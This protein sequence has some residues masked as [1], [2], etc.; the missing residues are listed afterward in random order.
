MSFLW[1]HICNTCHI[2]L[3]PLNFAD[4]A[5]FILNTP[6]PWR[7]GGAF[8]W[9]SRLK[10]KQ[11]SSQTYCSP[12]LP[13]WSFDVSAEHQVC[14]GVNVAQLFLE[15]KQLTRCFSQQIWKASI[16]HHV[17]YKNG[18]TSAL[19]CFSIP[20]TDTYLHLLVYIYIQIYKYKYMYQ[21]HDCV[22]L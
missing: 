3:I 17:L 2:L 10:R 21:K 6:W 12:S 22:S 18:W 16:M 13:C 8:L 5:I 15:H 20:P 4:I 1:L 14:V 11:S 7:L 9:G 19:I